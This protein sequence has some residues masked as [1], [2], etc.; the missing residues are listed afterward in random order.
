MERVFVILFSVVL[1]R[2][3]QLQMSLIC[4]TLGYC[5]RT[6]FDF[7]RLHSV[8]KVVTRNLNRVIDNNFYPVEEA[9]RSNMR[10]RPIGLGVQGISVTFKNV[11]DFQKRSI[12]ER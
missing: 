10:H 1:L 8:V 6:E 11:G 12:F 5:S 3:S 9:R 2:N 7:K 4:W